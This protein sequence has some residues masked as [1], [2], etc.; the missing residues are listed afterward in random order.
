MRVY[1]YIYTYLH[2]SIILY[3]AP[4]YLAEAVITMTSPR[5]YIGLLLLGS[6]YFLG[7]ACLRNACV[8]LLNFKSTKSAAAVAKLR[9]QMFASYQ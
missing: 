8:L 4:L 3:L 7:M 6:R 9:I 5:N 1:I 2:T